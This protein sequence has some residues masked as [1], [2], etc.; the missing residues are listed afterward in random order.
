MA[1]MA[2]MWLIFIFIFFT[3]FF[4]F[5]PLFYFMH[6]ETGWHFFGMRITR[7]LEKGKGQIFFGRRK[8]SFLLKRKQREQKR[9]KRKEERSGF[10]SGIF[11]V[12]FES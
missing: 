6:E 3:L 1:R 10:S 9:K 4:L 12:L 2:C 8:E 5:L 7:I 11:G